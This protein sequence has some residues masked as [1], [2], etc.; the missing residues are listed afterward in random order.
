M[1]RKG[2][3]YDG[4]IDDTLCV[5]MCICMKSIILKHPELSFE[6]WAPCSTDVPS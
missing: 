4:N 5:F 1:L 6:E 3:K 2:A